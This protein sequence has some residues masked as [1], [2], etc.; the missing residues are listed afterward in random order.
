MTLPEP[1]I[2]PRCDGEGTLP[3][4]SQVLGVEVLVEA[5]CPDC[6]CPACGVCT[7]GGLCGG[8]EEADWLDCELSYGRR[9]D[10]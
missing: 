7:G 4:L 6:C 5:P 8:H 3:T 10:R 9:R 2:C 1:S